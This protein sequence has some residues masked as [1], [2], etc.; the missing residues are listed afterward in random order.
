VSVYRYPAARVADW[1]PPFSQVAADFLVATS[2]NWAKF[3][4]GVVIAAF[5]LPL[6]LAAFLIKLV[7]FV[8][9]WVAAHLA[10]GFLGILT[11]NDLRVDMDWW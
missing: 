2:W 1:R 3:V 10:C 11:G 9:V 5:M 4:F 8:V 7:L 6:A